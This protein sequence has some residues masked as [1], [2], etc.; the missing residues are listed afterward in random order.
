MKNQRGFFTIIGL[1]FLLAAAIC[2]VTIQKTEK[3]FT[4]GTTDFEIEQ[5]LQNAADSALIE[6]AEKIRRNPNL[7]PSGS[8]YDLRKNRQFQIPVNLAY[9]KKLK[10]LQVKVYG[11]RG[12]IHSEPGIYSDII[13]SS[14]DKAGFILLSIA[15]CPSRFDNKKI[16]RRSFAYI[17]N[18]NPE[19]IFFMNNL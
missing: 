1:C 15:S 17:E 18:D 12:N 2:I 16:Y 13:L 19:I 9:N 4:A 14:N 8:P 6:A 5:E 7:L 3:N 11:E 10:N